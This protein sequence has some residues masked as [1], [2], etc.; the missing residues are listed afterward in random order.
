M[1]GFKKQPRYDE[2]AAMVY[3]AALSRTRAP[4]FYT[5]YGVPDS[6]D[7]RFDLLVLHVFM[8]ITK[9]AL[10]GRAGIAFN[11]SLFDVMFADMDQTLREMG[12][13]DMGIPKHMKRMMKA[14]NGRMHNYKDDFDR[15]GVISEDVLRRNLYGTIEQVAPAHLSAMKDY[16]AANMA[17][18]A[19][20]DIARILAGHIEFTAIS[21]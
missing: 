2:S 3:A 18:I 16:V 11:Q 4:Q 8:P 7:G 9:M 17:F 6:F 15:F 19:D 13:G 5:D 10:Q 21:A 1:F 14:F 12:I 20:Q